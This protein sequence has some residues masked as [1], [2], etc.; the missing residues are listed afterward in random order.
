MEGGPVL[1]I[2]NKQIA[3][4]SSY[5]RDAFKKRMV[6]H[7]AE[8]QRTAGPPEVQDEGALRELVEHAMVKA[9]LYGIEYEDDVAQLIEWYAAFGHDFELGEEMGWMRPILENEALPGEAK[10]KLLRRRKQS[11][12]D[13]SP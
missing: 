4:F 6:S 10:I 3:A 11:K 8:Q 1:V 13:I 2:R 5:M 7:L 9:E 12:A